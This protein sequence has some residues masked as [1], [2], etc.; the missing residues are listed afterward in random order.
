M[1]IHA[2]F[3]AMQGMFALPCPRHAQANGAG[4]ASLQARERL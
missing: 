4:E 3:G 2:S 1:A